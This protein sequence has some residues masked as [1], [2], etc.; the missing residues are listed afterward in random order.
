MPQLHARGSRGP[1]CVTANLKESFFKLL[2]IFQPFL[3]SSYIYIFPTFP[4]LL[5]LLWDNVI[6]TLHAQYV[7]SYLIHNDDHM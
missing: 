5:D 2:D 1:N 4:L 3:E 6:H 7:I